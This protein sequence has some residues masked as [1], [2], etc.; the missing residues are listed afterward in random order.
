MQTKYDVQSSDYSPEEKQIKARTV[1]QLPHP[2]RMDA[3]KDIQKA[4]GLDREIKFGLWLSQSLG[5]TRGE[6]REHRLAEY[7]QTSGDN[8][9]TWSP[10]WFPEIAGETGG[11]TEQPIN[12][13]FR[14]GTVRR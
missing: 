5:L 2:L 13:A 1:G 4:Q 7:M 9:A 11:Y 12:T 10:F 8:G 14:P 6:A 3:L